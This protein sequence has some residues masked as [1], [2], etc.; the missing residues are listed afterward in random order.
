MATHSRFHHQYANYGTQ[1]G[2]PS[3]PHANRG[4]VAPRALRFVE[5]LVSRLKDLVNRL[6]VIRVHGHAQTDGHRRHRFVR[7]GGH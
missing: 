2:F 7:S 3:R 5:S 4:A 1:S 6:P